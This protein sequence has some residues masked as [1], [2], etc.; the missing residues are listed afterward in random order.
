MLQAVVREIDP[1]SQLMSQHTVDLTRQQRG[2]MIDVVGAE[3]RDQRCSGDAVAI[4]RDG[5]ESPPCLE[6][7]GLM[8]SFDVPRLGRRCLRWG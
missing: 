4:G 5:S 2:I 6:G 8:P 7:I 3:R 1:A